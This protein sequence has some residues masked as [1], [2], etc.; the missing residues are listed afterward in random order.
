V[1]NTEP[2][3]NA[4]LFDSF[5]DYYDHGCFIVTELPLH[6]DAYENRSCDI[7]NAE[8]KKFINFLDEEESWL[9]DVSLINTA[10]YYQVRITFQSDILTGLTPELSALAMSWY[11]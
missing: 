11:D 5:G 8:K 2:L 7:D 10:P 1:Q 4:L 6:N 3:D 9:N